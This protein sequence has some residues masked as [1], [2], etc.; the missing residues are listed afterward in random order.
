MT[1]SACDY[2]DYVNEAL[3][4]NIAVEDG[5]ELVTNI[6]V[7]EVHR[8]K[9]IEKLLRDNLDHIIGA[10]STVQDIDDDND[11]PDDAKASRE[12]IEKLQNLPDP[13]LEEDEEEEEEEDDDA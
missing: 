7:A 8:L 1:V 11:R 2:M 10:L 13:D 6:A 3:G 5:A 9:G 12:L 4:I